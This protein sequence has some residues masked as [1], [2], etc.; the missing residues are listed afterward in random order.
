[1]EVVKLPPQSFKARK[2]ILQTDLSTCEPAGHLLGHAA[3][4]ANHKEASESIYSAG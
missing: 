3:G 2:H 4:R 1:M